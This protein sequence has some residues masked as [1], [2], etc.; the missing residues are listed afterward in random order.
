MGE[1]QPSHK[2]PKDMAKQK[3][4]QKDQKSSALLEIKEQKEGVSN[5]RQRRTSPSRK[6]L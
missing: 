2:I 3:T 4:R 5:S 1:L 6:I